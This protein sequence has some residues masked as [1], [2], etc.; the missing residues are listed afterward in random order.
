MRQLRRQTQDFQLTATVFVTQAIEFLP[1]GGRLH[2]T[3]GGHLVTVYLSEK[4]CDLIAA[5]LRPPTPLVAGEFIPDDVL[6]PRL[7]PGRTMTRVDLN[8]LVHRTRQDL[9]PLG[10]DPGELLARAP[11]GGATRFTLA[12]GA[13]VQFE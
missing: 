3:I 1:R 10:I 11:G 7:W 2:A 12:P 5:L 4:R 8:T 9:A 13:I 6:L